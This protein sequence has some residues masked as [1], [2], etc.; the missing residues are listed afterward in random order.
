MSD[1]TPSESFDRG[2][3]F[4]TAQGNPVIHV[5]DTV[6]AVFLGILSIILLVSLL[7]SYARNRR[8]AQRLALLETQR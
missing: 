4:T 2:T 8:L 1:A 6:G 7:T 5:R 3:H